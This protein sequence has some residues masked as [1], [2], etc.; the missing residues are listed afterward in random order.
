MSWMNCLELGRLAGQLEHEMLGRGVD[1]L[2][3]EDLGDAQ[4]LDALLALA[5]NL[6]QRQLALERIGLRAVRS[7]T[8]CTGTSRS[9]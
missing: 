6:D 8:R 2:G 3:A 9:S 5:G 1:H 7:R 4:R